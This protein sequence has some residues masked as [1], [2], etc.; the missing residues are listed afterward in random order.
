M[1]Q[2][3]MVFGGSC[4]FNRINPGTPG[5]L[6]KLRLAHRRASIF[7]NCGWDHR[8]TWLCTAKCL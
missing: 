4:I 7:R 8:R 2:R 3:A 5:E 6:P 1:G